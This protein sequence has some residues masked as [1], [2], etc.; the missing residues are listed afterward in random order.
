[1]VSK[2]MI[3]SMLVLLACLYSGPAFALSRA[4]ARDIEFPK[5]YDPAKAA[6]IRSVIQ[7]KQYEFTDGLVSYWPPDWATRLSFR[8]N[9]DQLNSFI[10]DLRNL[11]GM[12]VRI[13]LYKGRN[14]ELRRDTGWQL[15]FSHARPDQLTVYLNITSPDIDFPKIKMEW[16]AN[17]AGP[18]SGNAK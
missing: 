6:A 2:G 3:V 1:M 16:G 8:G 15:E 10:S 13:I 5:G 18:S 11:P 12:G 9:A 14:D 4:I 17:K 7:N